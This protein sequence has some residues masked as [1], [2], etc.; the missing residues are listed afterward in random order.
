MSVYRILD[1]LTQE[2]LIHKLNS[3]NKY[4]ICSN[5]DL[6]HQH[7]SLQFLICDRCSSVHEIGVKRDIIK[8][9]KDDAEIA[10]FKLTSRQ[11]ELHG[12]C[13]RCRQS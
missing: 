13:E 9:L 7:D 12:L 5:I 4:I 6:D 8:Q 1:Y 11:L 2:N 3:T 10:G